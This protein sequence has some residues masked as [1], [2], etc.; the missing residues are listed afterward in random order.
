[1]EGNESTEREQLLARVK[2]DGCRLF[3]P[4][5]DRYRADREIVLAAVKETGH[6]LRFAAEECK[7]DRQIVLAAVGNSPCFEEDLLRVG[8]ALRYAAEE[9][10]ADHEI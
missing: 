5:P 6:A 2:S 3:W 8:S 10:K 1:M 9:C 7:R 4:V